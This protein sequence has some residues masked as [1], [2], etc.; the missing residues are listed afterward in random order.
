MWF[1]ETDGTRPRTVADSRAILGE[2]KVERRQPSDTAVKRCQ[3]KLS[4]IPSNSMNSAARFSSVH[5]SMG[6]LGRHGDRITVPR[7]N[8]SKAWVCISTWSSLRVT[9]H[10][11]WDKTIIPDIQDWLW[12]KTINPKIQ[13]PPESGLCLSSVPHH[14]H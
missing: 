5:F 8:I 7:F 1:G 3:L 12:D 9:P 4:H 6:K 11:L 14:L 13:W 2:Q 10:C